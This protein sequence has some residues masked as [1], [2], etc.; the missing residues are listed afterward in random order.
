MTRQIFTPLSATQTQLHKYNREPM[1]PS[2]SISAVPLVI[3][4]IGADVAPSSSP[5]L[6]SSSS[7]GHIAIAVHPAP[8]D[9]V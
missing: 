4:V 2:P 6:A 7:G 3:F 8:M 1:S 9:F 5:P